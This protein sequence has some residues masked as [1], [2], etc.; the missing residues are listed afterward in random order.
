M[1][2]LGLICTH[3]G[4]TKTGICF[5]CLLPCLK[6]KDFGL[7]ATVPKQTQC[8]VPPREDWWPDMAQGLQ[9]EL[10]YLFFQKRSAVYNWT[11]PENKWLYMILGVESLDSEF[12]SVLALYQCPST[13]RVAKPQLWDCG[14]LREW[15]KVKTPGVEHCQVEVEALVLPLQVPCDDVP[16]LLSVLAMVLK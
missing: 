10:Q 14:N 3:S 1:Y 11:W 9:V 6:K 13:N 5:Q 7:T 16:A 12:K 8:A 4:L 2:R 15:K